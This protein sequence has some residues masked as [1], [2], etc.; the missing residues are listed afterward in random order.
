MPITLEKLFSPSLPLVFEYLGEDVN[1]RWSPSRYTGEMDDL[2]EQMDREQEESSAELLA[3]LQ[4]EDEAAAKAIR[5][6]MQ[7]RDRQATLRFLAALIVEWDVMDGLVPFGT[8]EAALKKL[9]PEFLEKVFR[10]IASENKA[11]PPKPERSDEPSAPEDSS[12]KSR[13]G[14]RS[15]GART[16]S[17]SPRGT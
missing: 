16:T 17:G 6:T 2:A 5:A 12:V 7:H 3:A 4:A 14:S 13:R 11:D 1:V 15:S 8:D 9:P 10:E